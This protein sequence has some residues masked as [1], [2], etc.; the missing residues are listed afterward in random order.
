MTAPA[1]PPPAPEF[2]QRR[3]SA[4]YR[5]PDR[6]PVR[7]W[8][9]AATRGAPAVRVREERE[10]AEGAGQ[11]FR[12]AG[13][14]SPERRFAPGHRP[15]TPGQASALQP[16]AGNKAVGL[17]IDR[18]RAGG[19]KIPWAAPGTR[20]KRTQ[21][22]AGIERGESPPQR[23]QRVEQKQQATRTTRSGRAGTSAKGKEIAE[24]PEEIG[25]PTLR[26]TSSYAG[27]T[28][29][30]LTARQQIGFEQQATLVRADGMTTPAEEAYDFWQEVTDQ[31]LQISPNSVN[32]HPAKAKTPWVVDGLF[33]PP[34]N[35]IDGTVTKNDEHITFHD[36]PGFSS[37]EAMTNGYWLCSY[38]VKFRWKVR[39]KLGGRFTKQ[40]PSWTSTE[41]VHRVEST[42][43]P[44]HP[45]ATAQITARPAGD[46]TWN[47]ELPD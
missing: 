10:Q 44:E 28:V 38:E 35:T 45:E 9:A 29:Q 13:N 18:A 20:S 6:V 36:S 47:V 33:H 46:R 27:P 7:C 31:N 1:A 41:M 4:A 23:Q 14:S 12:P 32:Y 15:M 5:R 30:S 19:P 40:G 11:L 42:F 8:D 37:G 34:Y 2:W 25:N 43:D 24:E 16:A 39:R 3:P 26:F 22:E 21:G 17:A